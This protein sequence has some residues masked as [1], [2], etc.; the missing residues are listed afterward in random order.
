MADPLA[1][2]G[3][4]AWR[5][6]H[7]VSLM[8]AA[9]IVLV[10]LTLIA[11]EADPNVVDLAATRWLQRFDSPV[12]SGFMT[13]VSWFGF[14][15]Q[16]WV[17]PLAVTA[18]FAL[19]GYRVEALW[20]LG[21]QVQAPLTVLIK[22]IVHRP[23]P[24]PE[25]VGVVAPLH[26]PSFPSGHVVQY[27]TLFGIAFFLVYVLARSSPRR[28]AALVLLAVPIV[29]V[30]PSRLY[31]GQHWLSDVLGGYAVAALLLVP[32][33]WAYATWR[34]DAARRRVAGAAN[35]SPLMHSLA[36]RSD[37]GRR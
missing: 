25:L 2:R 32:Y 11:S 6:R 8:L 36:N 30:G 29:L 27:A 37:R 18:P 4:V 21:S 5:T 28:T 23:R 22:Q 19:R 34:L 12:F 33:C 9:G 17:L 15:P 14:A 16:G 31:L 13:V 26:D 24:S 35:Q 3:V 20:V 10:V 1:S 7:L